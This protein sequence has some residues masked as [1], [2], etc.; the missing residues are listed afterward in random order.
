MRKQLKSIL[1]SAVLLCLLS[2][3]GGYAV[4]SSAAAS[5]RYLD[6]SSQRAE[7]MAAG[8]CVIN[9]SEDVPDSAVIG[10]SACVFADDGSE[11]ILQR[12]P[13]EKL[14]P[15]SITKIMTALTAIRYGSLTDMVTVGEEAVITETGASL[16]KISPGD[17]LT[18][19]QLLYGLMLPSGN[20]AAAAIAVAISGSIE[21]FAQLM[22][23]E[24]YRIGA[25]DTHFINPHGLHDENHYT[26]AYD[27]YLIMHAALRE[28]IFR[29]IIGTASYTAE[30]NDS[31][32]AVKTQVW[33]NSN[34]YLTGERELP[35]GFSVIGGKT[36]T[37]KA[38]GYCLILATV[39]A[40]GEEYI[41]V[42]LKS[43]SRQ[44]LYDDM[45]RI[46]YEIGN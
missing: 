45:D 1:L 12:N 17:T 34:Q 46:I 13:F 32:G 41:S 39:S 11:V 23:E 15:A 28:P 3:C 18:L 19:E 31:S 40:E 29:Q 38:A 7:G 8:L 33:E 4:P 25:T 10:E 44:H 2:G 16:C 21:D 37:T 9:G 30:Y 36:G 22:N 42:V 24:A 43:D 26:T 6:L 5:V 20:D 27:L 35:N 14:Y